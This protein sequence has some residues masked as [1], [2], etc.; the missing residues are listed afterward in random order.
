MQIKRTIFTLL[1]VIGFIGILALCEVSL[2][3]Q[4]ISPGFARF[5]FF[6]EFKVSRWHF[7][8]SIQHRLDIDEVLRTEPNYR[9]TEPPEAGRPPFDQVPYPFDVV[10]NNLGFRDDDFAPELRQGKRIIVLGD[11]V[12]FG[13]GVESGQ[14]FPSLLESWMENAEVYNLGLQGCTAECMAKLMDRHADSFLPDL[15]LLQA[16]GNDLDQTLWRE[17]RSASLPGLGIAALEKAKASRL[18]LKL[19][20]IRGKDRS[21]VQLEAAAK[22]TMERYGKSM[23]QIMD[24][25]EELG[26]PL[27]ALDLPYAYGFHYGGHLSEVCTRSRETCRGSLRMEFGEAERLRE[28][29]SIQPASS[30]FVDATA[31][32]MGIAEESL[33]QVF[34]Q[35]HFFHDI[36]HLSP[37]GHVAV[38]E[39]LAPIIGDLLED[40]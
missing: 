32:Q 17:S 10:Y 33:E 35:R 7:I 15:V 12:A 27:V 30:D 24:K 18:L 39:K 14:S 20:Q 29:Y 13:K 4:A 6:T 5:L 19:M 31:S 3:R 36:C 23:E 25:A 40:G 38:A 9:Y 8:D 34:S 2:R 16:S 28:Q 22:A 37:L 11:S 1:P 26:I 21:D